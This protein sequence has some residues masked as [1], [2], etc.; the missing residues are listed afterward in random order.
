MLLQRF[1]FFVAVTS[2]L[3]V[4][5]T[6][7]SVNTNTHIKLLNRFQQLD[8]SCF[9]FIDGDNVRG[10]TSFKASKESLTRDVNEFV[11]SLNLGGR[12]CLFFDHGNENEAHAYSN[13]LTVSFSGSNTADD[14][15]VRD[16]MWFQRR[17]NSSVLVVT[18]DS[19]LKSRCMQ[20]AKITGRQLAVVDSTL[21]VD[22]LSASMPP[23]AFGQ[24]AEETDAPPSP[25]DLAVAMSAFDPAK[26][27]SLRREMGVRNQIKSIE[28]YVRGGGSKKKTT[29]LK[30]RA[31]QLEA[32]LQQV[33]IRETGAVTSLT[34]TMDAALAMAPAH[35]QAGYD[36][37]LR[38]MRAGSTRGREE[39]WERVLLA[40]RFRNVLLT[41]AFASGGH[42]H[43]ANEDG[44]LAIYAR[45]VN[46]NFSKT[47]FTLE[48]I[49]WQEATAKAAAAASAAE[50]PLQAMSG[51]SEAA[52]QPVEAIFMVAPVDAAAA[53]A[54]ASE[55]EAVPSSLS[56]L[57]QQLLLQ[58]R[59]EKAL[60]EAAKRAPTEPSARAV[61]IA[62]RA[63]AG[64]RRTFHGVPFAVTPAG[65]RVYALDV[66]GDAMD[67][68]GADGGDDEGSPVVPDGAPLS[69]AAVATGLD[70][71]T[72]AP[73]PPPDAPRALRIVAVSDTHGYESDLIGGVPDGDV[74]VHAGDYA[75]D[76]GR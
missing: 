36:A 2:V 70:A 55:A 44:A 24:P 58:Q 20:G 72:A 62:K 16:A 46:L 7:L 75:G 49:R 59:R 61:E 43:S 68:A 10:K 3:L 26:M 5:A 41:R 57:H 17:F 53:P 34:V 60:M 69:A 25:P 9:L 21:F 67:A 74:L 31:Q 51:G 64:P 39:T 4:C 14:T 76:R 22:L 65:N 27:S 8:P 63:L 37:I 54:P 73:A 47:N 33:I 35:Q 19:G 30:K 42:E 38:M 32:R 1:L 50:V 18:S 28:K 71:P 12:V 45:E 66:L 6:A 29:K 48:R 23:E 11:G 40:E 52:G 56:A 15:I 13:N